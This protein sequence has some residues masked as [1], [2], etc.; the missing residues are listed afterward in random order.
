MLYL[1]VTFLVA[2]FVV[3][4]LLAVLPQL[5]GL[6]AFTTVVGLVLGTMAIMVLGLFMAPQLFGVMLTLIGIA[7]GLIAGIKLIFNN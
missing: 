3:C 6:I 2:Y 7:V 4:G 1:F 5:F